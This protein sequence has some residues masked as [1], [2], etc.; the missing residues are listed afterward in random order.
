MKL[1]FLYGLF[2][3]EDL[4]IKKNLHPTSPTLA[5]VEGYGLRIGERAT[6]VQSAEERAYG[7]IM[8]IDDAKL[9]LL[10]GED[11]VAD[12]VP[13]QVIAHDL[14]GQPQRVISYNLPA[15]KLAGNNRS[16]ARS[17]AILVKK[18]GFPRDYVTEVE[19]WAT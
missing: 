9:D 16:Y 14:K 5:C 3:D 13:E 1:V 4:L 18:L 17:L 15:N 10:Y 11:S 7:I 6:L 12:Y 8:S 2:M 19:K